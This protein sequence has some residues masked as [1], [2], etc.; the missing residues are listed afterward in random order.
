M[1]L[2]QPIICSWNHRR[3]GT[4]KPRFGRSST[5]GGTHGRMTSLNSRFVVVASPCRADVC[6]AASSITL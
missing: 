5:A 4:P 1:S 2:A 3:S 6:L